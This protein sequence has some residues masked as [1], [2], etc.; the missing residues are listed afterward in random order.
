MEKDTPEKII[1]MFDKQQALY[2]EHYKDFYNLTKAGERIGIDTQAVLEENGSINENA[3]KLLFVSS[4]F[5]PIGYQTGDFIGELI[6][7]DSF[8]NSLTKNKNLTF[9]EREDIKRKLER[10]ISRLIQFPILDY[11]SEKTIDEILEDQEDER[12]QRTRGGLVEG[13]LDVPFT[14]EDPADRIDP[15]TGEPYSEQMT[16]LGFT[17]D[18]E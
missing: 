13:T 4:K 16:R 3:R 9:S 10:K 11:D 7:N 6:I 17:I 2:Y 5:N 12:M 1:A 18:R 15:F 14:R 8:D